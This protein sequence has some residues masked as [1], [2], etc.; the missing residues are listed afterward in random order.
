MNGF[1]CVHTQLIPF[2]IYPVLDISFAF[3]TPNYQEC[4]SNMSYLYWTPIPI[5][6][7]AQPENH[8]AILFLIIYELATGFTYD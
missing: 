2:A 8:K 4:C 3:V 5:P 6:L 7:N 1:C